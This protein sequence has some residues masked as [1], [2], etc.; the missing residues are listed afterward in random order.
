MSEDKP[1]TQSIDD[2][3]AKVL[4]GA[5][6]NGVTALDREGNPVTLTPPASMVTAAINYLKSKGEGRNPAVVNTP[7]GKLTERM[8]KH[9]KLAG[10]NQNI[11]KTPIEEL[12]D[13]ATA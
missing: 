2:A 1:S 6:E 7:A 5:L 10:V 12:D 8:G 4:L 13:R 3:I 9:L 11:L